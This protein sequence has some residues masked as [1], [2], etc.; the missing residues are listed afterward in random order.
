MPIPNYPD[1]SGTQNMNQVPEATKI[2]TG[3]TQLRKTTKRKKLFDA[4]KPDDTR[5]IASYAWTDIIVP[6][7]KMIAMNVIGAFIMNGTPYGAPKN[8]YYMNGY[9]GYSSPFDNKYQYN[10]SQH[11]Q[12]QPP[13]PAA[14]HN[15]YDYATIEFST[16]QEAM[17]VLNKMKESIARYKRTTVGDLYTYSGQTPRPIDHN[18]GWT[19]VNNLDFAQIR[20]VSSSYGPQTVFVI[21]L[22]KAQLLQG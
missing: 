22:P 4:F 13:Q 3:K 15:V 7:I 21:D 9:S 10:Y 20:P 6:N 2:V 14:V 5:R 11:Y 16:H 1:N 19:T 18:Y 17:T 12:Q 8:P